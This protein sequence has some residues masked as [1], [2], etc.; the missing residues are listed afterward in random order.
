MKWLSGEDKR[1][2]IMRTLDKDFQYIIEK[3]PNINTLNEIKNL[4]F[5]FIE[6]KHTIEDIEFGSALFP[7]EEIPM[8]VLNEFSKED[9]NIQSNKPLSILID[10][11]FN[12]AALDTSVFDS[13]PHLSIDIMLIN[14]GYWYACYGLDSGGDGSYCKIYPGFLTNAEKK[15][16]TKQTEKEVLLKISNNINSNNYESFLFLDESLNLAYTLSFDKETRINLVKALENNIEE[17]I[18]ANIIPIGIFYTRIAD[19]LRGMSAIMNKDLQML[20]HI[21]DRLL[22]DTIIEIGARTPC[23]KV[24]S[25]PL[26]DSNIKLL[27]FYLKVDNGNILRVE[28]PEIFKNRIENIHL[29]VL[30]QSILGEGY[31]LALQRA[32]ELAVL[33]KD[34]RK[35]IELEIAR[36][37]KIPI[38]EKTLSKKEVSKRWPIT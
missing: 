4:Y 7:K 19:I 33:T 21:P 35:I 8:K 29:A 18:K 2:T 14:V 12:I 20:G 3:I 38:I 32:H 5:K 23:F 24:Y 1:L 27:A 16:I 9:L 30:A 26:L 11:G 10:K 22:V 17:A 37:L 36:K 6:S 13:G 34:D 15:V 25:K 31:P 28:F